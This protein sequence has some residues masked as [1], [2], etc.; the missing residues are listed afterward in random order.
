MLSL[1]ITYH[2]LDKKERRKERKKTKVHKKGHEGHIGHKTT[3]QYGMV[4]QWSEF[5]SK[6]QF[7]TALVLSVIHPGSSF[8]EESWLYR[9]AFP[10]GG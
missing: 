9:G 5:F 10:S 1:K 6:S 4:R 2:S 8:L 3:A 7:F